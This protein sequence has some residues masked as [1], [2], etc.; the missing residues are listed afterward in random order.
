[1]TPQIYVIDAAIATKIGL[2]K[3]LVLQR[4]VDWCAYNKRNEKN[5]KNGRVWAYNTQKAWSAEMPMVSDRKMRTLL[6][7]LVDEGFIYVAHYGGTDRTAWYA[8]NEGAVE[9]C[10]ESGRLMLEQAA[11]K[12]T[13]QNP[14]SDKNCQFHVTKI[15]SCKR[16]KL[17]LDHSLEQEKTQEKTTRGDRARVRESTPGQAKEM[18]LVWEAYGIAYE[19]R[20]GRKPE[21]VKG[22]DTAIRTLLS[23]PL[24]TAVFVVALYVAHPRTHYLERFHELSIAAEDFRKLRTELETQTIGCKRGQR[25]ARHV[26]G[27]VADWWR[28]RNDEAGP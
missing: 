10:R 7:E 23:M 27:A 22:D 6:G 3:A 9:A 5:L 18:A 16:Q 12:I 13:K 15:V 19:A 21:W 25:F 1:M 28:E 20:Y 8:V 2:E 11:A 24:E 17:S 14:P 26:F 4:I